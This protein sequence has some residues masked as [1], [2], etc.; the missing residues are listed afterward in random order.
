M[1]RAWQ[2]TELERR[3]VEALIKAHP[4]CDELKGRRSTS[5]IGEN[6]VEGVDMEALASDFEGKGGHELDGKLRA[7]RSSSALVVNCFGRWRNTPSSL[8]FKGWTDFGCM[9]FEH[10]CDTELT[11]GK[12][13]QSKPTLDMILTKGDLVVAVESKLIEYLRPHVPLFSPRYTSGALASRDQKWLGLM[14]AMIPDKTWRRLGAAQLVKHYF[15]LTHDFANRDVHLVYLYWEPENADEIDACQ[16]H[17]AE[18]DEFVDAVKDTDI[19]F[20]A[21][22]YAQLWKSWDELKEPEWLVYHVARLQKRYCVEI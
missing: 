5:S 16:E 7:V 15:G 1:G 20:H 11:E 3:A 18:V 14:E 8:R 6:L 9:A 2:E 22:T 17:R 4:L 19:T 10:Q 21:M 13:T 12:T